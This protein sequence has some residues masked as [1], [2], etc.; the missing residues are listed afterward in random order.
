MHWHQPIT[1]RGRV[2]LDGSMDPGWTKAMRN[3][4]GSTM[5]PRFVPLDQSNLKPRDWIRWGHRWSEVPRAALYM[6][7]HHYPHPRA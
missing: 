1:S 4:H 5:D 7:A 6:A 2:W 3:I